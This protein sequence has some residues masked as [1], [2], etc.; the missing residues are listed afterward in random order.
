[1]YNKVGTKLSINSDGRVVVGSGVKYVKACTSSVIGWYSRLGGVI[2]CIRKNGTII[3]FAYV[4]IKQA[5]TINNDSCPL[6]PVVFPVVEGDVISMTVWQSSGVQAEFEGHDTA[7][8]N[9]LTVEVV[10]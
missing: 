5:N 8:R 10:E 3:Q 2:V 6:S 4:D 9:S 1:M 7:C